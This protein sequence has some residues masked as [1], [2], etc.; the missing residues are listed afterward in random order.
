MPTTFGAREHAIVGGVVAVLVV[1]LATAGLRWS[2]GAYDDHLDLT[3]TF[4]RTGQGLDDASDVRV[5]GVQVGTVSGILLDEQGRPVVDMQL[6]PGTRVPADTVAAIEA[7]SVFGPKFVSLQVDPSKLSGPL[8]EDGDR[9]TRT[10]AP[11]ELADMLGQVRDLLDAVDPD[12]VG[13]LVSTGARLAREAEP[14]VGAMLDAAEELAGVASRHVDDGTALLGDL[15]RL[16]REVDGWSDQ[17]VA[18]GRDTHE[19]VPVLEQHEDDLA[20]TLDA[21]TLAAHA[22]SDVLE[23]HPDAASALVQGLLPALLPP[24]A[25]VA[26]NLEHLPVFAEVISVFFGELASIMHVEGP[27]GQRLGAIELLFSGDL[28]EFVEGLQCHEGAP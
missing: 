6:E 1:A 27:S 28:C 10:R 23:R 8:L 7:T 11:T 20:A 15:E 4:S 12:Q 19:L 25:A 26:G 21:V 14:R 2:A 9:I 16:T 22:V 5:R 17:V 24:L 3:A 13:A 18:I